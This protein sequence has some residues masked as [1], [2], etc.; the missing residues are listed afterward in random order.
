M[1]T[2]LVIDTS[3]VLH[4]AKYSVGKKRLKHNEQ[5]TFVIYGFM[6][7]LQYLMKKVRPNIVAFATDSLSSKRR[8]IYPGYKDRV[9]NK[10]DEQKALDELAYPQF[11]RVIDHVLP[12]IGYRNIIN[13]DGL[14]ADDIIA[15]I[16]LDYKKSGIVIVT[17]DQDMYQCLSNRICI[18]NINKNKYY[19]AKDFLNEYDISPRK[20]GRVKSIG[21]CTSDTVKGIEG[22]GEGKAIQYIKGT[23]PKNGKVYPRVVSRKGKR[24]IRR[25]KK[26]VVLPFKDTPSTKLFADRL[27]IEGLVEI[28]ETYGFSS[29]LNDLPYWRHVLNIP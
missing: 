23:M 29:I 28:A 5:D 13:H 16:C 15:R 2:I 10:T 22:V 8:D 12:T 3:S 4:A 25:N 24:I 27:R 7:K 17:S 19:T 20:W 21:G 6:L 14:E 11:E 26:L 9:S 18:F 1:K